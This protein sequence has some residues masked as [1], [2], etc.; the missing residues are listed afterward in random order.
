MVTQRKFI[1]EP[2]ADVAPTTEQKLS[3]ASRHLQPFAIS[4]WNIDEYAEHQII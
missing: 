3:S 2:I 4:S 1:P